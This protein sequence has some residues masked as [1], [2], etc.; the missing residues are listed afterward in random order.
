MKSASAGSWLAPIM[1]TA[2]AAGAAARETVRNAN[3]RRAGVTE[4]QFVRLQNSIEDYSI[5]LA[6]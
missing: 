6:V 5:D 3:I 2:N 1:A 4:C